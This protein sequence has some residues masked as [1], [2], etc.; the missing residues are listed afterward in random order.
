MAGLPALTKHG[1]IINSRI[2]FSYELNTVPIM[3]LGSEIT[4]VSDSMLRSFSVYNAGSTIAYLEGFNAP[5][6]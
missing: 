6:H 2:E 5:R 1:F 4:I 3:I